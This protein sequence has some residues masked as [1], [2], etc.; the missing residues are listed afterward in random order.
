MS[1]VGLKN[2]SPVKVPLVLPVKAIKQMKKAYD[3]MKSTQGG[4]TVTI[5]LPKE[6]VRTVDTSELRGQGL[7]TFG[8]GQGIHAELTLPKTKATRLRAAKE[9]GTAHDLKL[10]RASLGKIVG[11]GW[12]KDVFGTI[13]SIAKPFVSLIPGVG[14]VIANQ[15]SPVVDGAISLTFIDGFDE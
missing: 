6:S 7:S 12:F 11:S 3:S 8:S 2:L 1:S 9:A 5:N 15:L 13:A 10:T 4:G 14:G